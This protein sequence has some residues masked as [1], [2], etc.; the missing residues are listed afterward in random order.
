[1]IVYE[2]TCH[3]GSKREA[4]KRTTSIDLVHSIFASK[5]HGSD[6]VMRINP[7]LNPFRRV[8]VYTA[9]LCTA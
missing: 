8:V 7:D 4:H 1:M 6:L 2:F 9:P 3:N 5:A